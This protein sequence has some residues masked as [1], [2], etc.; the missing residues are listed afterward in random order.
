MLRCALPIVGIS[1]LF[2]LSTLLAI[3]NPPK[4]KSADEA[5]D[6]K[7]IMK[8]AHLT[9]RNRSTRDNLDNEEETPRIVHRVVQGYAAERRS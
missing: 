6:I 8:E 7:R 5:I 9:P 3:A 2:C 4:D 1:I